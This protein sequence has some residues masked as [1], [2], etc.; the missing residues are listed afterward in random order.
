MIKESGD[1]ITMGS[2][3]NHLDDF[4]RNLCGSNAIEDVWSA[5]VSALAAIGLDHVT[6]LLV[7]LAAPNDRPFVL[8]TM[9]D[10]WTEIYLCDGQLRDDPLF[11]FCGNFKPRL[12]GS[13]F[14]DCYPELNSIERDRV[15]AAGEVGCRTGFAV[16][17]HMI[18]DERCGGWNFGSSLSRVAFEKHYPS[19][20]EAAQLIGLYAHTRLETL[21]LHRE[22]ETKSGSILSPREQECLSFLAKGGRT[23]NIA[24]LLGISPATVEFHLK[25]IKNKLGAATR[26]EALVKAIAQDQFVIPS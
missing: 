12:T 1:S 20:R 7:R 25:N 3:E 22:R 6:Y 16:P 2:S 14:L 21:F 10:W 11:R 26:E 5:S 9:P 8:T 15:L 19:I 17:I 4:L 13:E 23:S 18:G 24:T